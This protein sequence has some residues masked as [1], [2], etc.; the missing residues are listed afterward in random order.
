MLSSN[1]ESRLL[2][3]LLNTEDARDLPVIG[4]NMTRAMQCLLAF[5]KISK[6]PQPH[7]RH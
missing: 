2:D 3:Q 1:L 4:M 6:P 7:L 5:L